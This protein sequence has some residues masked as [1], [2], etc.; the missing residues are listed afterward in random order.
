M[1]RR[2]YAWFP[3]G[4]EMFGN[5]DGGQ[6]NVDFGFKDRLNGESL[7]AYTAE[8][9]RLLDRINIAIAAARH[10]DQTRDEIEIMARHASWRL[11]LPHVNFFRLR[12][13]EDVA[14]QPIAVDGRR[15]SWDVYWAHLEDVLPASLRQT[16]FFARYR[17]ACVSR[18]N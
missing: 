3:R 6:A 8:V 13:S 14:C 2:I 16:Q 17:A 9:E 18:V 11:H 15:L 7:Q 10:P 4:V 12:G 5:P 1:Q